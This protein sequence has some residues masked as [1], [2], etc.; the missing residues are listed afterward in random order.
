[1]VNIQRSQKLAESILPPTHE[2]LIVD[3]I[4]ANLK[5]L[6]D[7]LQTKNYKVRA[8]VNGEMALN[9]IKAKKPDLIMLDIKMPVMDGFTVAKHIQSNPETSDIPIIFI[10]ALG[11]TANKLHAF[12]AGGVD[13]ITKPYA[14]AEVLVRLS[15]HLELSDYKKKLEQKVASAVAEINELNSELKATQEEVI[16][17]MSATAEERSHETG[18]HVIRVAEYA[19]LLAKL[20]NLEPKKAELIHKAAPMHDL[21]K[22]AIPDR[23]LNKPGPLTEHEMTLM[24]T[25]SQKGYDILKFSN[26]SVL[27]MAAIIAYQHHEKFDGTGYPQGLKG[28]DID[29]AGRICAIADVFDALGNTRNYKKAWALDKILDYFKQERGL[30]FD[31]ALTDL[32]FDNLDS[33]IEISQKFSDMPSDE[34]KSL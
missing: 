19:Y 33:F 29:I 20:F 1:M 14:N 3:D 8:A 25:H 26:H 11:E 7:I 10:S 34:R 24:K 16:I 9:S 22:V 12:Q 4:P 27:Q 32:F 2:I 6:S 5:L 13:Y 30:S 15:T 18:Q 28:E 31:P 23:I 17:M 21:G